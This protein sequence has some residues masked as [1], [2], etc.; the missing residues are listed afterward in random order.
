MNKYGASCSRL[1]DVDDFRLIYNRFIWL[2]TLPEKSVQTGIYLS[3][4]LIRLPDM[5]IEN[6]KFGY[7]EFI[8]PNQD[9]INLPAGPL[10]SWR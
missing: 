6:V 3:A 10:S 9:H 7:F 4:S 2:A 8:F 5:M 1:A